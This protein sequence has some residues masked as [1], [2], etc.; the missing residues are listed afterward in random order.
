MRGGGEGQA[1]GEQERPKEEEEK[2]TEKGK[3]ETGS[4]LKKGGW[5]IEGAGSD[6]NNQQYPAEHQGHQGRGSLTILP[7]SL[8]MS[9]AFPETGSVPCVCTTDK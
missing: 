1:R 8:M 9:Q 2:E 7:A 4:T 3:E 6:S 5:G